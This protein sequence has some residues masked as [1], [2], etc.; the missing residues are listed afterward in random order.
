MLNVVMMNV[1]NLNVV[2]LNVVMLIVVAPNYCMYEKYLS[3]Y[4]D[5]KRNIV[6]RNLK[7]FFSIFLNVTD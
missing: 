3:M 7:K 6:L 1:I 4:E 5:G 2:K